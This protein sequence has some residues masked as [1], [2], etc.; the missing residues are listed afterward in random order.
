MLVTT[1]VVVEAPPR[2]NTS[3]RRTGFMPVSSND[4]VIASALRKRAYPWLNWPSSA[5]WDRGVATTGELNGGGA[6]VGGS[7]RLTL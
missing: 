5:M 2:I 7:G 4:I 1:S 3:N 6:T